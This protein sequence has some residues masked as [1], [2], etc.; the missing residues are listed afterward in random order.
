M[1]TINGAKQMGM[2]ERLGSIEIGKNADFIVLD[3]DPFRI[4]VT[5]IHKVKV[6]ATY[7][8]GAVVY[9]RANESP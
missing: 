5:D 4:P 8:D 2:G 9:E 3:R 1:F 6:R 7:I